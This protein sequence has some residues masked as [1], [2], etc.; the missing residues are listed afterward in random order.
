ME[1]SSPSRVRY[2]APNNGAPLT[3]PGR[4][5]ATP[6]KMRGKTLTDRQC[7]FENGAA[8]FNL[9]SVRLFSGWF[10]RLCASFPLF[11]DPLRTV[12]AVKGSLRRPTAVDRAEIGRL[13]SPLV[14]SSD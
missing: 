14:Q 8:I 4:P 5:Q 13:C 3:A 11:P 12:L 7:E 9:F 6:P 1:R 2:A 10:L